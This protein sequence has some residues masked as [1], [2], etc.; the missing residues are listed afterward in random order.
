MIAFAS[1]LFGISTYGGASHRCLLDHKFQIWNN[2][3]SLLPV[4]GSSACVAID[5]LWLM[6]M[7]K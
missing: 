6:V 7:V 5:V 2:D 1:V 4:L 3:F